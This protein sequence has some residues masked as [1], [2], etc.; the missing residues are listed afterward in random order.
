MWFWGGGCDTLLAKPADCGNSRQAVVDL[1][2]E[3]D[4]ASYSG[5]GQGA[6]LPHKYDCISSDDVL[7]EM[8]AAAADI[9]FA[10]MPAKWNED[11]IAGR[12]LLVWT[13]LRSALQR[14]D[15][16]A[17]QSALQDFE[18]GYARPLWAAL[19]AGQ[20]ARLQLDIPGMDSLRSVQLARA[21]AWA[22]WRRSRRLAEYSS[23]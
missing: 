23:K 2:E 13:G 6:K 1:S 20:I 22:L 17:W 15:L 11:S 4:A 19:R 3:H 16:P 9:P 10:A 8:F 7:A 5:G 14:G 18:I 12:Q 21:D